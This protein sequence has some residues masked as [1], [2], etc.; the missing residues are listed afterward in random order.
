MFLK[1]FEVANFKWKTGSFALAIN[2]FSSF[3]LDTECELT[4]H[5]QLW[6]LTRRRAVFAFFLLLVL[7]RKNPEMSNVDIPVGV[8]TST[9]VIL[10]VNEWVFSAI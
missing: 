6:E 2:K 9:P 3:F 10:P 4:L 5:Q 1:D 8:G 7:S